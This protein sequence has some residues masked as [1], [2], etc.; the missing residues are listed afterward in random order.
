[1]ATELESR[2]QVFSEQLWQ[3]AQGTG[4]L[5]TKASVSDVGMY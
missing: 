4:S 3:L 2:A 1:M 5:T